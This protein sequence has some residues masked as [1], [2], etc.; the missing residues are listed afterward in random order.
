MRRTPDDS[1]IVLHGGGGPERHTPDQ[2]ART[3]RRAIAERV[4]R[5]LTTAY[6]TR[7]EPVRA[8]ARRR[9]ITVEQ[10]VAAHIARV[11]MDKV[12]NEDR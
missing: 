1:G 3:F 9:G 5:V 2:R 7:P 6:V 11:I 8:E 4:L 10:L 12:D